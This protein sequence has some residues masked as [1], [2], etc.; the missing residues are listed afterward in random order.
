MK[1]AASWKTRRLGD[2]PLEISGGISVP[3]E[4]RPTVNGEPAIL[5]LSA[6][7]A[8]TFRPNENKVVLPV[9]RGRLERTVRAGQVLVSRS[10]TAELVGAVALVEEDSPALFL[11]DLIWA[12]DVKDSSVNP[13]WL[14]LALG[15]SDARRQILGL[16]SGTS[17]SMKKLSI[18]RLRMLQLRVPPRREQ[19]RIASLVRALDGRLEVQRLLLDAKRRFKRGLMQRLLDRRA[20]AKDEQ[21]QEFYLGELFTEREE[22]GR[23]K[24]SLL[25]ITAD[26]GV[27]RRD[28]LERRD[29]SAVDKS[30]YLRIAPGDVGYNTMRMWQG[31][32][33]LSALEGIVS[34]AYTICV[35]NE[36]I[37]GAF[38]AAFFK[39][40][41][42]V[43]LFARYSQGLVDDTL[44][45]KFHNF[46][47]IRVRIPPIEQQRKIAAAVT[48][49]DAELT[50][51][52]QL[53]DAYERQ[54]RGL[55]DRLLAGETPVPAT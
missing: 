36:K 20:G 21:W 37:D 4:D 22:T 10:N 29:T 13:H 31:V 24:L 41:P 53:R 45:L 6:I 5:K 55:L 34:P 54:K 19:D 11:P 38:A 52:E 15:A 25:S 2:L 8:G 35:P 30:L 23:H 42:V 33:A 9:H 28:D 43:H 46:A 32:S 12:L 48:A 51:L 39:Y 18:A 3:C 50:V 7:D 40:A 26:R 14:A 16:A 17:G 47:K 44:S 49:V 1:P 27:I